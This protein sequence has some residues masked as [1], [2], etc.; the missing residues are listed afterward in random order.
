MLRPKK[1]RSVTHLHWEEVIRSIRK[2]KTPILFPANFS[3]CQ[4]TTAETTMRWHCVYFPVKLIVTL[5]QKVTAWAESVTS[6][7]RS[8]VADTSW[9]CRVK[10]WF[11]KRSVI[12][13]YEWRH[14]EWEPPFWISLIMWELRVQSRI[15]RKLPGIL[16]ITCL[17]ETWGERDLRCNSA[18]IGWDWYSSTSFTW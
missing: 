12:G 13:S 4:T 18:V 1:S 2:W 17:Y 3:D 11:L 10:S 7:F 16:Q 9:K 14:A 6:N 8:R 5:G 15:E